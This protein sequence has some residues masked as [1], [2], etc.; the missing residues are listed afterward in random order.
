MEV[1]PRTSTLLRKHSSRKGSRKKSRQLS[2]D[3]DVLKEAAPQSNEN[4]KSPGIDDSEDPN[5]NSEISKIQVRFF[6]LV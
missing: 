2:A 3:P 1:V 4:E 5:S 6:T